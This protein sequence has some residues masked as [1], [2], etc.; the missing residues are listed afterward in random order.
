M[1]FKAFNQLVGS[2]V[3][4]THVDMTEKSVEKDSGGKLV[5]RTAISATLILITFNELTTRMW[6]I[7]NFSTFLI[8]SLIRIILTRDQR[9]Q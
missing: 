7:A 9:T 5:L 2:L 3:R 6:S 4:R 1:N 8:Y